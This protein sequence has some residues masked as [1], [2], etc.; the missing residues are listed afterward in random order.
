MRL[1]Y[2]LLGGLT[3]IAAVFVPLAKAQPAAT[4]WTNTPVTFQQFNPD[5]SDFLTDEASLTRGGNGVLFN[6]STSPTP[7][8]VLWAEGTIDNY[9]AL[10]YQPMAN[11]RNT[12][13]QAVLFANS[14]VMWLENENIYIPATFSAWGR[15]GAGGWTYTRGTAPAAVV[16]TPVKLFLPTING[17]SFIFSY[18]NAT[19]GLTYVVQTS[20]NL[21]SWVPVATNV[22]ASSTVSFTNTLTTGAHYFRVQTLSGQ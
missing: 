15:R 4:L 18:S 1:K 22:A 21:T 14:W 2:L 12:D 16:L 8:T 17:G 10:N 5:A 9:L 20:S 11:Y 13:L 3:V 6:D 19:P 7:D